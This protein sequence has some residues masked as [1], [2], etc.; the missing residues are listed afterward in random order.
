VIHKAVM[1]RKQNIQHY[2]FTSSAIDIW[3]IITLTIHYSWSWSHVTTDGRSVSTSWYR[4]HCGT[5][6][7]ILILSEICCIVSVGRSLW[8]KVGS[9]SC[10]SLSAIICPSSSFFLG[11]GVNIDP[12]SNCSA[13]DT[14][15]ADPR[16]LDSLY[17]RGIL[18]V[19]VVIRYCYLTN[20][21]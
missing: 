2:I 1:S 16:S 15:D 21:L 4:A 14:N 11:G 6:Y 20:A 8:R 9:V 3:T 7:Q 17:V 13:R 18:P 19:F 12:G 5:C 10:Q